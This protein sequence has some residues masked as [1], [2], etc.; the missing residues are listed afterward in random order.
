MS[1]KISPSEFEVAHL[2]GLYKFLK[3]NL[4]PSKH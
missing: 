2:G 4:Y 1:V 3:K